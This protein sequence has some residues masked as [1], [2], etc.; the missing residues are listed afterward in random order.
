MMVI[1]REEF[2]SGVKDG[3][4]VILPEEIQSYQV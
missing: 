2:Q 1:L 3:M 4:I